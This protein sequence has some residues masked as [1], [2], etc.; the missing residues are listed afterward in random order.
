MEMS[1]CPHCGAENSVRREACYNCG[2]L[3]S[4]AAGP[5]AGVGPAPA[6]GVP[7]APAPVAPQERIPIWSVVVGAI[8]LWCAAPFGLALLASTNRNWRLCGVGLLIGLG[9]GITAWFCLLFLIGLVME[10]GT[11]SGLTGSP[12]GW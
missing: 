8:V 4:Q 3:L 12:G 11:A 9:V 1:A 2:G 10:A 5:V 6:P 7:M